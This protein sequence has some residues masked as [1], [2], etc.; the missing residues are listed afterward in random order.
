MKGQC[1]EGQLW[2]SYAKT[3]VPDTWQSRLK[4]NLRGG[5]PGDEKVE[6][7]EDADRKRRFWKGIEDMKSDLKKAAT[8]AEATGIPR[9][10]IPTMEAM[11][12]GGQTMAP[13]DPMPGLLSPSFDPTKRTVPW[14]N[15]WE[16]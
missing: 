8:K 6:A 5:K 7:S 1:P 15:I 10:S 2:D 12:F 3:C 13:M 11:G 16:A 14:L 4:A 9:S